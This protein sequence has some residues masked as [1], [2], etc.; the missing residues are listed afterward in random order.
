[1]LVEFFVKPNRITSQDVADAAGVSRTTVS[2][3]LNNVKGIQISEGTRQRVI[4]AAGDLGYV[5]DAAARALASRRAQI[6]GLVLV[7]ST[8]HITSDSFLTQVLENLIDVVH[9]HELR[10]LVDI[11]E[12]H[13]QKEAYL[14]LARSKHIDGLILSGPRFDDEALSALEE[15]NFP[16]VLMGQLPGTDLYS[17]DVDNR[18]AACEAVEHL[19]QHRHQQIACITNAPPLYTAATD[20]L[21]GYRDALTSH[22]IPF[23]ESIVKYGEFSMKSGYQRMQELLASQDSFSAAFIGS[24][25]VAI[26]A[27]AAIRENGLEVPGDIAVVGFDDLPSAFYNSPP[28]TTVHIPVPELARQASKYLIKML[29]GNPVTREQIILDTHLVIRGSCGAHPE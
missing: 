17:V 2:L 10:L 4:R 23:K 16:T 3:V 5:P 11:I 9:E 15:H 21:N 1:V 6:I 29:S 14:Q 28:L 18:K 7:R 8:N 24:D 22:G 27:L 12:P 13:H 20:R 25:Q 19:I 26:G